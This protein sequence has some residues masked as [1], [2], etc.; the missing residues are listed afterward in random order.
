VGADRRVPA[1]L[2]SILR[3]SACS[4][5]G[6]SARV[7]RAATV[8]QASAAP[9]ASAARWARW[10][11]AGSW[12]SRLIA[13]A[14]AVG[15]PHGTSRPGG[16]LGDRNAQG[17]HPIVVAGVQIVGFQGVAEEQL[18]AEHAHRPFGDHGL[19]AVQV[20]MTPVAVESSTDEPLRT[21]H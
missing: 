16:P 1:R 8:G 15:C 3:G 6:A 13:S 18:A 2:I 14:S 12:S 20:P 9:T 19:D 17:Q 4:A 21:V 10:R 5:T 7:S 11:P